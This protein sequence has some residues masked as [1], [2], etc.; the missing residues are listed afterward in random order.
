MSERTAK[1]LSWAELSK[2]AEPLHRTFEPNWAAYF[3][4]YIIQPHLTD[5]Y[6]KLKS[7]SGIVLL[8]CIYN[9]GYN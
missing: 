9:T 5:P 8:H 6:N 4:P 7:I 1:I 3:E 2:E